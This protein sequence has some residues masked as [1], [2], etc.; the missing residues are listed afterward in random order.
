MKLSK[1][2]AQ[3]QV[4]AYCKRG[5]TVLRDVDFGVTSY[6]YQVEAQCSYCCFSDIQNR[7]FMSCFSIRALEGYTMYHYIAGPFKLSVYFDEHD[8]YMV[9]GKYRQLETIEAEYRS[10]SFDNQLDLQNEL[11]II[12]AFY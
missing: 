3:K 2:D 4:C 11:K 7:S 12:M 5:L 9:I 10:L 1:L 6:Q 8:I